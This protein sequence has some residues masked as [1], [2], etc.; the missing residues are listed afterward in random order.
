MAVA[1]LLGC[2]RDAGR[3]EVKWWLQA[4]P[5]RRTARIPLIRRTPLTCT[6]LRHMIAAIQVKLVARF[7]PNLSS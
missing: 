1:L 3:M 7:E 4:A 5:L 2:V 6:R